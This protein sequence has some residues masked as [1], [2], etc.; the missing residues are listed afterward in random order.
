MSESGLKKPW[1]AVRRAAGLPKLRVHDLRH[2][3]ITRMAEAGV[4][5]RVAMSFAGH[6]TARMQQRYEAICMAAKRGWG[7]QVWGEGMERAAVREAAEAAV[8][9][10]GPRKPVAS[11]SLPKYQSGQHFHT[12]P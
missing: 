5:L 12:R 2:T 10:A 4:G 1:D 11:E 8:G 7:A 6:M 3:G 9:C